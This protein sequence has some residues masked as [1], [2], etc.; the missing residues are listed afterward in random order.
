VK[1]RI[2]PVLG[3]FLVFVFGVIS[4]VVGSRIAVRRAMVRVSTLP[5]EQQRVR[6]LMGLL[7][8]HLQLS[9]EQRRVLQ[10]E[11]RLFVREQ[12]PHVIAFQKRTRHLRKAFIRRV[13]PHLH[14]RQRRAWKAMK[15]LYEGKA[16][17]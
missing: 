14:P 15:R 1:R 10:K 3:V 13:E 5:P 11:A 4:G 9:R 2:W 6:L 8:V 17:K 12:M 7:Q 16:T